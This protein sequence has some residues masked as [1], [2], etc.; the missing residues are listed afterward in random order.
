MSI[1]FN[2][3]YNT[4]S[5]WLKAISAGAIAAGSLISTAQADGLITA[6]EWV[7]IVTGVVVAFVGVLGFYSAKD[8]VTGPTNNPDPATAEAVAV[9]GET[10]GNLG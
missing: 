5:D 8:V 1:R 3:T 2:L 10:S 9:E 6:T 4:P 7:G